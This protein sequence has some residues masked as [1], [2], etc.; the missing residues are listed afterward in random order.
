MRRREF[1]TLF[2]S[3]ALWPLAARA[4]PRRRLPTVG[5][6]GGPTASTGRPWVAAFVQQLSE[7]GWIEGQT[8]AIEYRWAEGHG[9]RYAEFATE[10]VRLKVDVIV[11]TGSPA[12]VAAKQATAVIPIVFA[13]VG[14]PVGIGLVA[15]LARPGGNLTGLSNQ[16]SDLVSKRLEFLREM[17]SSLDRLAIMANAGNPAVVLEMGEVQAQAR[18]LGLKPISLEIR[19]AEDIA[20]LFEA[21]KGQADALY[22]CTDPLVFTNRVRI[23]TLALSARLPT[24][25]G[26]RDYVEAGGLISYGANFPDLFRRVGDHVDKILRGVAPAEIPV[27]QP[28]RFDLVIN[29]T[30]A[31]SLGLTVPPT[32]LATADDVIE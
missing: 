29:L 11:T 28:T 13:L 8:V 23:N 17:A 27:E 25:Y 4:Q 6:L 20:P 3:A 26:N 7:R 12:A 22:V 30:T 1:I 5:F 9:E 14:D 10:F 24:I 15:S 2:G 16:S 18:T 31:K 21:H 19:Q 32:L